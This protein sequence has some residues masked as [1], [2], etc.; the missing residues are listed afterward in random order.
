MVLSQ[1]LINKGYSL[2]KVVE[3]D[4]SDYLIIKKICY[5]KYVD[6]YYGGWKNNVQIEMNAKVFNETAKQSAFIKILLNGETVGFF[7]FDERNDKIGGITI[8]MTEKAQN[9]GIGSFYLE[10]IISISDKNKKPIFLKVFKSNPAQNLYKR[11][12]F[13]TY[14][15]S[16]THYL[17]RYDP[18]A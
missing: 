11:Y 10:H 2:A 5:E 12:G 4:L 14:D 16:S 7:A 8:Q 17:M 3:S 18:T 6:E 9:K 13:K 1:D 15:E